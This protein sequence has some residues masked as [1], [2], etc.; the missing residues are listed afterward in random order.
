MKIRTVSL[1]LVAVLAALV[2]FSPTRTSASATVAASYSQVSVE[3]AFASLNEVSMLADENY[4]AG[5]V[6]QGRRSGTKGCELAATYIA[7]QFKAA[8][9]V[10]GVNG[11]YFLPFPITTAVKLGSGN[12]LS[13]THATGVK[14]FAAGKDF[15]P[16]IYSSNANVAGPVVFAGYGISAPDM[17]YDDY[18]GVDVKGKVVVVLR[19]QPQMGDDKSAFNGGKATRFAD[20]RYKA[21]N[22]HQHGAAAMI[23]VAGPAGGHQDEG[24][25]LIKLKNDYTMGDEGLP[26][27]MVT[28][29]VADTILGK[30]T[31]DAQK[32]IEE[33][34]APSS[35]PVGFT[36]I[37][38]ATDVI[39]E[40]G[41]TSDVI[42]YLPGND[43]NLKDEI[44]VLGAHYDHLGFGG[45]GSLAPDQEGK[46]HHGA[47]DNAS[48]T[49]C[50]IEIAKALAKERANLRRT[51]VFMAF[52]GEEEGLL[53]SGYYVQHPIWPLA[54]TVAMLNMDMVGRLHE[55]K[56]VVSGYKSAAEFDGWLKDANARLGFKLAEDASG[57][58]PSDQTS[59]LAKD[60]PV[61]FFFTGAHEDYHR[62][63]DTVDKLNFPG[64]LRVAQYVLL[65]ATDIDEADARPT[66]DK[67]SQGRPP[68][69]GGGGGY[70]PYLG[71]IPDFG[72]SPVPGVHL[73]AVRKDSPAEKAGLKAGDTIVK[74]GDAEI[75]NLY[76]LFNALQNHKVGDVVEIVYRRG[77]NTFT[78]KATLEKRKEE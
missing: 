63:S 65:I 42:G 62:P 28:R 8:G 76:D 78:T 37:K 35:F 30:P 12:A 26:A 4:L 49:T 21:V 73:T 23:L 34:L 20:I 9:L 17:K 41:S 50:V 66:F 69:A 71:T 61:L 77:D 13:V 15:I 45:Q 55:D 44:I 58:A 40:Q 57:Y 2:L 38:L 1:P 48:G 64:M 47:D 25:D 19:Y 43:P 18:A 36:S 7:R 3:A 31:A 59:F 10:P 24:N 5:D 16:L 32:P 11:S 75:R 14:T 74:L 67:S 53:G 46:I 70:G 22:A 72:E 29:H 68:S 60:I 54:S 39:R 33:S 52:S 27:I 51:F 56:L 6:T